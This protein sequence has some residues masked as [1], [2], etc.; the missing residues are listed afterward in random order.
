MTRTTV[1]IKP[2]PIPPG[3]VVCRNGGRTADEIRGPLSRE[4]GPIRGG[5]LLAALFFIGVLFVAA[6][7]P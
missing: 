3:Y 7:V 1:Y 5:L 2:R 6:F 4:P